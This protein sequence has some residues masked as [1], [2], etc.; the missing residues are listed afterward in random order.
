MM[1]TV[2]LMLISSSLDAFNR[3]ALHP[4]HCCQLY[5]KRAEEI[6][7]VKTLMSL[8]LSIA[9]ISSP[10]TVYQHNAANAVMTLKGKEKLM[11]TLEEYQA[12][13]DRKNTHPPSASS[14]LKS[15]TRSKAKIVNKVKPKADRKV[16]TSLQQSLTKTA[17]KSSAAKSP[18]VPTL[19]P[20]VPK[21]TEETN[22][23]NIIAKKEAR[24]KQNNKLSDLFDIAK[25]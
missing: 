11:S 12:A 20:S 19:T 24:V 25:G 6:N 15:E 22:V 4:R 18:S 5:M 13:I 16:D 17:P 3:N 7:L 10:V 21:L 8:P 2:V 9:L 14:G 23:E 1:L